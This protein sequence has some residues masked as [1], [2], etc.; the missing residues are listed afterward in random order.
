MSGGP[1][2][3]ERRQ[4]RD[5]LEER[6]QRQ[7]RRPAR[8]LPPP[9]LSRTLRAEER[10]EAEADERPEARHLHRE[11]R[12]RRRR[13]PVPRAHPL[14]RQLQRRRHEGRRPLPRRPP[15]RAA[16][17]RP[18]L[19][20]G[21][22]EDDPVVAARLPVLGVRRDDRELRR[23]DPAGFSPPPAPSR[24]PPRASSDAPASS[25]GRRR[26]KPVT[27]PSRAS[28]TTHQ[29]CRS[30]LA[31]EAHLPDGP[32]QH[33][34]RPRARAPASR[35]ARGATAPR[36]AP[37]WYG[38]SPRARLRR[39]LE[40]R[41]RRAALGHGEVA[42]RVVS[43][44]LHERAARPRSRRSRETRTSGVRARRAAGPSARAGGRR[45]TAAAAA[46]DVRRRRAA[47]GATTA[48]ASLLAPGCGGGA[49]PTSPFVSPVSGANPPRFSART[50]ATTSG[51]RRAPAASAP[52]TAKYVFVDR[53]RISDV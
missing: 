8:R 37:S 34:R 6:R 50:P 24:A 2:P 27:R 20:D 51:R 47:C 43:L 46:A 9:Q 31:R 13:A 28:T 41:Q 23:V 32:R 19:C 4:V 1:G 25:S 11:R 35:R 12:V 18:R 29:R 3:Q 42:R 21:D 38:I 30:P 17:P 5:P 26:E 7:E 44:R 52:E 36:S 39:V 22:L 15:S 33:P 45:P 40:R 48:G 49:D 10:H 14:L 16:A 53:T